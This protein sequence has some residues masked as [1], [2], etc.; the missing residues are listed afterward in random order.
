MEPHNPFFTCEKKSWDSFG[1]VNGDKLSFLHINV[2]SLPN[3]YSELISN[4]AL[5]DF[6]FTFIIVVETWLDKNNDVGL[7]IDGYESRS[8][9][10]DSGLGGGIK[11]YYRSG[12]K[13]SIIEEYSLC[14]DTCESL[15]LK[16]YIPEFGVLNV[17]GIY[18]PPQKSI[19]CFNSYISEILEYFTGKVVMT[20]DF[21]V[22]LL[23][24]TTHVREFI[25]NM[26]SFGY[27]NEIN[28]PTY[29]SPVTESESS[30]LDHVWHNLSLSRDSYVVV[31]NVA[32]HNAIS[33]IFHL[34]LKNKLEIIKFRNFSD[35][36]IDKFRQNV[37][38]EFL[39]FTPISYEPNYFCIYFE[40]FLTNLLNKY[41]PW[42]SKQIGI[43][44]LNSPWITNEIISCIR[45]K[46]TWYR[47]LKNGLITKNSYKLYC[48]ALRKLLNLAEC[49]Y[50][51]SKFKSL[52]PILPKIG[53]C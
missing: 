40:N 28:L 17:G 8:L 25:D 27:F 44:R 26:N 32:D 46:H 39:N 33:V 50:V 5:L 20:G 1:N 52:G 21:N 38:R 42:K 7:E 2:R 22:N 24:D 15:F 36:N 12:I 3:K 6:M 29:V 11:I 43:K 30:C 19:P 9:Y 37:E 16:A 31:P 10:R 41:F 47:L 53:S 14:S 23:E 34:N 4:L 45:K 49:E 48:K 35:E 51:R 13:A 18:R